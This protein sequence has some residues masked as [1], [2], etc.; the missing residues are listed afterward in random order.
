MRR[1]QHHERR[2]LL[3]DV[4]DEIVGG[5][6]IH[7]LSACLA[8]TAPKK[9][10]LKIKSPSDPGKKQMQWKWGAGA[11]T[12]VADFGTPTSSTSYALCLYDGTTLVSSSVIP[13]GGTCA[14][15]KPCWKGNATSFQFKSKTGQPDGVLQL[16]LKAGIAGKAQI[17]LKAKGN[18]LEV[19]TLG[20]PTM[21]VVTAQLSRS[22]S[23]ICWGAVFSP[24]F[25]KNTLKDF[26]DKTD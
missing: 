20:S 19:P 14:S 11:A 4:P 9:G 15:N 13:A 6:P 25:S 21:G 1:R 23:S 7:P 3:G 8:P 26:S 16:K 2:R 17:Q 10:Q 5:C 18:L 12:T 22:G 24:P